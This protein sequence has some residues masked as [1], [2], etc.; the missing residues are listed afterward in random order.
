LQPREVAGL[1]GQLGEDFV[2]ELQSAAGRGDEI[3]AVF[4]DDRLANIACYAAG[5]T[6]LMHDL[7]VHFAAPSLYTYRNFTQPFFRGRRLHAA[8]LLGAASELFARGVPQILALCEWTNYPAMISLRRM[9][10]QRSGVVWLIGIGRLEHLGQKVRP[11]GVRL[12]LR[13]PD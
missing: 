11:G 1:A 12:K 8:G 5:R 6:P 7:E 3:Y 2:R 9:G 4:E 10:W 13:G